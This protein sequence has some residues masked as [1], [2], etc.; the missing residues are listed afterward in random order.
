MP[1]CSVMPRMPLK[2]LCFL[3]PPPALRQQVQA[4]WCLDTRQSGPGREPAF[5]HPDGGTGFVLNLG[6]PLPPR[7]P[8]EQP[9][10]WL[11]WE[12]V[13]PISGR[14]TP[15]TG[16][17]SYGVRFHPGGARRFWGGVPMLQTSTE[18]L[19]AVHGHALRRLHQ[20][21]GEVGDVRAGLQHLADWLMQQLQPSTACQVSQRSLEA[22]ME[23][24]SQAESVARAAAALHLSRRALERRFAEQV[25]VS[26]KQYAR[27]QRI[28]RA[29]DLLKRGPPIRQAEL[30]QQ[31]GYF[32]EAHFIHDFRAMV[33]ITPGHYARRQSPFSPLVLG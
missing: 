6:R 31:L 8:G 1:S 33:G 9:P 27:I 7:V 19:D 30:A 5:M 14:L 10:V 23:Q 17:L 25:G 15:D 13:Q 24:V 2:P 28:A 18:A 4:I 32:D 16:W 11:G 20:R 29:R 12:G 26:P 21:L 22:V 3:P